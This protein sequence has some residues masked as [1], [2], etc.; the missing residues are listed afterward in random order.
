M[1]RPDQGQEQRPAFGKMPQK[2]ARGRPQLSAV[3]CWHPIVRFSLSSGRQ[4]QPVGSSETIS[5]QLRGRV[6]ALMWNVKGDDLCIDHLA[7]M[8]SSASR[9]V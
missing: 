3:L 9:R 1:P 7:L 5:T 6:S 8:P 4:V 2:K